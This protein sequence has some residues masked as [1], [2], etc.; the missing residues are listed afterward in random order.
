MNGP[1]PI[2][3]WPSH[4]EDALTKRCSVFKRITVLRETDSTQDAAR[5]LNAPPG[6]V[7]TTWR[8]TSGRGRLDR[9]WSDTLES[10]V[11]VTLVT[12]RREPGFLAIVSAVGTA[13]AIES[14]TPMATKIKWPNDIL[15]GGRKIAGILIEQFD[16]VALIGVGINV[17][18]MQW[19]AELES[20]AVSLAQLGVVVDRLEMLVELIAAMDAVMQLNSDALNREFASRD[21]LVGKVSTFRTVA[22]E[23]TGRVVRVDPMRGVEVETADGRLERL[24]AATT[25]VLNVHAEHAVIPV[26][27]ESAISTGM[28]VPSHPV[29]R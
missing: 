28:S 12:E 21:A 14:V 23:I 8:Q 15:I 9:T 29:D 27:H 16:E 3:Q 4:I 18:Q 11:A 2:E 22:R 25:T 1:I 6:D 20:R 7:V 19:P 17:R 10:G 13:R 24:P 5:R 26:G